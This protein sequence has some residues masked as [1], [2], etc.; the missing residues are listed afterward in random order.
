MEGMRKLRELFGFWKTAHE[1]PYFDG[2]AR[3]CLVVDPAASGEG[4]VIQVGG[5]VNPTHTTF[6]P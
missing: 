1:R 5:K 6:L 2:V 4:G 3:F